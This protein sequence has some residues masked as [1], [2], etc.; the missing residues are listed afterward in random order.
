M[1]LV[2]RSSPAIMTMRASSFH[3]FLNADT[4][5]VDGT[6]LLSKDPSTSE[7]SPGGS[8][9]VARL[10]TELYGLIA[11]FVLSER[12]IAKIHTFRKSP[13]RIVAGASVASRAMREAIMHAWFRVLR[14]RQVGDFNFIDQKM[15]WMFP[16]VRYVSLIF[17]WELS[18]WC[19][20][21]E[22]FIGIIVSLSHATK[23]MFSVNLFTPSSSPSKPQT[24][25]SGTNTT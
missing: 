6:H 9:T 1:S 15:N 10:P 12:P 3:T 24:T 23:P 19:C 18:N 8:Y 2:R 25:V 7:T 4:E 5:M 17:Q 13:W 14:I 11:S 22:R 20:V 21:A 16:W